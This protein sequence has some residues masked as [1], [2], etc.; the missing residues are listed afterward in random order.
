[1]AIDLIN[2]IIHQSRDSVV[3]WGLMLSN[4]NRTWPVLAGMSM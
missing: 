2:E 4:C 3:L 1:M